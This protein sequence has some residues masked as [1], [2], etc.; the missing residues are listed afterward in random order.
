MSHRCS[1][2]SYLMEVK[3]LKKIILCDGFASKQAFALLRPAGQICLN[4]TTH[5][6][7][8]GRK[9]RLLTSFLALYGIYS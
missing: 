2:L 3:C 4:M 9:K 6:E 7:Y 8:N 1:I 5:S